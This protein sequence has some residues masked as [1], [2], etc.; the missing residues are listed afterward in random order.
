MSAPQ[1][2]LVPVINSPASLDAVELAV[3]LA[4]ARKG[5]VYVVYV[6]EVSRSLPMNAELEGEARRGEQIIRRAEELA[7]EMGCQVFGQLLQ[8]REAGA[9][10]VDE[11]EDRGVDAI[12]MGVGRKKF[13]HS[14]QVSESTDYILKHAHCQVWVLRQAVEDLPVQEE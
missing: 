9:A 13:P 7:A 10:I 14:F 11:A 1:T 12:V 3:S 5:R 8:A 4:K 2:F 6:I